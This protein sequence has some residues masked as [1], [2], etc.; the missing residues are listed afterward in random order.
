M[1][2]NTKPKTIHFDDVGPLNEK[3]LDLSHMFFK[4]RN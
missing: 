1:K 4:F 3:C 2:P